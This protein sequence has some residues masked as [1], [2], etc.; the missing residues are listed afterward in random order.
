MEF[1]CLRSETRQGSWNTNAIRGELGL[2]R[3]CF[4]RYPPVIF[5]FFYGRIRVNGPILLNDFLDF[6]SA[7][8]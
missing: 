7:T 6:V 1:V 8:F 4:I 5:Y 3:P 2:N